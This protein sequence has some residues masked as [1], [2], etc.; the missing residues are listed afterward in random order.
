MT[1][2]R[3]IVYSYPDYVINVPLD[4]GGAAVA[5]QAALARFSEP[6]SRPDAEFEEQ[7]FAGSARVATGMEAD[8]LFLVVPN[9][10]Q[11]GAFGAIIVRSHAGAAPEDVDDL[12]AESAG[13]DRFVLETPD[14]SKHDTP[15]GVGT[16]N[17]LRWTTGEP[18]KKKG[19]FRKAE[20]PITEQLSWYWYIE[21]ESGESTVLNVTCLNQNLDVSKVLT[22]IV[23]SFAEGIAFS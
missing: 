13:G 9:P 4:E 14:V 12:V 15:L 21:D 18:V 11:L 22:E 8:E 10:P 2:P 23:D 7:V 5:A 3:D 19:M 17:L 20:L 16:R 1:V 6:V